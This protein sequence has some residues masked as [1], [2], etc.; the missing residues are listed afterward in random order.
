MNEIFRDDKRKSKTLKEELIV[1]MRLKKV[2]VNY[3]IPAVEREVTVV[4]EGYD[5]D[6]TTVIQFSAI[7]LAVGYKHM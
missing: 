7:V 2:Y 5:T 4:G 1:Q 3:I 6:Q